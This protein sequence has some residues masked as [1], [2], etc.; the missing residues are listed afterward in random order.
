MIRVADAFLLARTKLRL[1]IVRLTVTIVV[2][3]LIFAVLVFIALVFSG[4]VSSFT[5][6]QSE[7]FGG[8][9]LV[10][11]NPMTYAFGNP[12][13]A[14]L[15]KELEKPQAEI[16]TQKKAA[17]KKLNITYDPLTDQGLPIVEQKLPGVPTQRFA[18][19][20]SPYVM[21]FIKQKNID[22][23]AISYINFQKLA[24]AANAAKTYRSTGSAGQTL[25][26]G[27]IT[28]LV[29]GKE[30]NPDVSHNS[31]QPSMKGLDSISTYGWSQFDSELLLPFV[32][33]GQSLTVGTDG[34][35]PI[36][37]PFSAA[38]EVLGLKELPTTATT[39]E[40]LQ[41]IKDVR[42]A[43]AGKRATI[44]YRNSVSNGLFQ[45]AITQQDTIEKNKNNKEF[46]VPSL[47]YQPPTTACGQISVKKDTR[48]AEEK[49]QTANEDV[50]K[51]QFGE[52]VDQDQG[53]VTVRIVGLT[54]EAEYSASFSATA[55]A[56]SIFQSTLGSG[57]FS[58]EEVLQNNAIAAKATDTNGFDA[59][60][61]ER[62]AYYAEFGSLDDAKEFIKNT[63][64][65][66][67]N[68]SMYELPTTGFDPCVDKGKPFYIYPFGNN[69]GAVEEL[70]RIFWQGAK[71][72][73]LVVMVL[74]S[75]ILMGNVGKIIAD[76][77]R[78]TAVFRA[79]GA[80]RFDIAQIY[81]TY[82][83]LLA[84]LLFACAVI[85]GFAGAYWFDA[86]LSPA[87]S[88]AAVLAYN[89]ADVTKQFHLIMFDAR[90][91]TGIF[92]LIL[93]AAFISTVV[94]LFGNLRRNPIKDMRD[95][96]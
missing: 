46:I 4:I 75:L 57:W 41:R 28:V 63:T 32:L 39:K 83:F 86:R 22:K 5:S 37:A 27:G 95:E 48:T 64:C 59:L 38:E 51:R 24:K 11:A 68:Q 58:P 31:G 60:P 92:V 7:G 66:T 20:G 81:M 49:K 26:S 10:V 96:G 84:V 54:T 56:Q 1:R 8:R 76:S 45:E 70:R 44:C 23:Q 2:S 90:L 6:F 25:Q 88:V 93:I 94:P 34:S 67:Q 82:S 16:I 87:M 50:F 15:I 42:N 72:A 18:N 9:Y 21:N 77:R 61:P 85:I 69:A 79:L 12:S 35:I 36:I 29:N 71:Y 80:K 19:Y 78:E 73:V 40:K 53:L 30:K 33:P 17:A 62:L 65:D 52:T 74:A 14:N 3:A 13:D 43:I 91:L 55:I 47:I 89:A